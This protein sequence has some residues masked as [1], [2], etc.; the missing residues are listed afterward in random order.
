MTILVLYDP[1]D[2]FITDEDS[3]V[4]NGASVDLLIGDL[5]TG[6]HFR[7]LLKFDIGSI[8]ADATINSAVLSLYCYAQESETDYTAF[9]HRALVE[10]FEGVMDWDD[11]GD[12]D[13]SNWYERNGN[14]QATE[15]WVGGYDSGGVS[16]DD[17]DATETDEAE[18]VDVGER[19]EW[20]LAADVQDFLDGVEDNHGW[21]ILG[22]EGIDSSR[23]FFYST[24]SADEDLHPKLTIDY[25]P[26]ETVPAGVAS[27]CGPMD[28]RGP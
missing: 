22:E 5:G 4:N 25:T 19:V 12:T 9:V 24:D 28:E 16:G 1:D 27:C 8:P 15:D 18:V 20:D 14:N 3:V 7:S 26:S 13:G 6:E 21:F 2:T 11:P 23:K 10:W 17:W